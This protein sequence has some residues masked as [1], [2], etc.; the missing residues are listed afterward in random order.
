MTIMMTSPKLPWSGMAESTRR[1]VEIIS[2]HDVYWITDIQGCYGIFIASKDAFKS[3]KSAIS[4]NGISVIKR[5]S[6]L[7]H[8]ELILLLSEKVNA[9]IFNKLCEDLISTIN[10][11]QENDAMVSAIEIRLQRWQELL[12]RSGDFGMSIEMQTG[13]FSELSFIKDILI[14]KIGEEQA[15]NAWVG[16]DFDKQDFLL[17]HAVVEIKSYRTS[18]GQLV[19][20]SSAEQLYCEK[21]PLYL[22]SYGLTQSD[23]GNS[24]SS[25]SESIK[26]I[27]SIKS[28]LLFDVFNLKLTDYGYIPELENEPYKGFLVDNT[29]F[30]RVNATFPKL[31]PPIIPS[32]IPRVK[33]S[34]DLSACEEFEIEASAIFIKE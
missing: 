33:Y 17:D 28:K 9:E 31:T 19:S 20:I 13:L 27:L 3:T 5:N 11:H 10:Q 24:V 2:N 15:I 34:I 23:N 30:F 4:L 12:K 18:K 7:G 1:R 16:P 21:Q 26:Q 8:G 29:K 6:E 22:V 14:P 25:L 32:Q